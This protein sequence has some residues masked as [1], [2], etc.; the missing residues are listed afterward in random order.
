MYDGAHGSMISR[1]LFID[2]MVHDALSAATLSYESLVINL[3]KL[4]LSLKVLIERLAIP[5]AKLTYSTCAEYGKKDPHTTG[6]HMSP[7]RDSRLPWHHYRNACVVK[8]SD[9]SGLS[10]S[11]LDCH[12]E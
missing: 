3:H 9:S 2:A 7:F 8:S 1:S 11:A 6:F 10:C 12:P 5:L 4:T